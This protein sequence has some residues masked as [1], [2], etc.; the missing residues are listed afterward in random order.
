MH[1]YYVQWVDMAA[2]EAQDENGDPNDCARETAITPSLK[3]A[4]QWAAKRSSGGGEAY[5]YQG[6]PHWSAGIDWHVIACY[7]DGEPE[8]D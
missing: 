5:V 4:L 1:R 3:T 8:H 6:T 2:L 7:R